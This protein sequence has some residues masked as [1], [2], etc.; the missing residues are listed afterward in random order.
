VPE[1]RAVA[2]QIGEAVRSACV[3]AAL[4]GYEEA[5][6][7]GLCGEGA[8]EAAVSAMRRLDLEAFARQVAPA[9][10]DREAPP[11]LAYA[12]AATG[13]LS[14]ALLGG[15]A[16]LAAR[17]GPH[18]FLARARAIASR[19]AALHASLGAASRD[20]PSA[21]RSV[22][23]TEA[24]VEI[25]ARCAQV[26]TLSAEVAEHGRETASRDAATALKLAARAAECALAAAAGELRG[27]PEGDW[28]RSTRRRMWRA[29]LL[30]RRALPAGA[31]DATLG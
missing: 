27:A 9:D 30:L 20:A 2:R 22:V 31:G 7:S 28:T 5:S 13:A 3:E 29:G 6:I 14:A 17:S 25:A 24:L 26:A 10:L 12:V 16:A 15:A 8:F 23:A 18:A 1:P 11:T 19:A 4:T 21:S